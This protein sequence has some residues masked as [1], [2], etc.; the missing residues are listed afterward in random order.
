MNL[1]AKLRQLSKRL[2]APH[3]AHDFIILEEP[4]EE[5]LQAVEA[6]IRACPAEHPARR[7]APVIVVVKSWRNHE[8]APA[9]SEASTSEIQIID[10]S[11][12][13]PDDSLDWAE[14]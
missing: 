12:E 10:Y 4:T 8:L 13:P 1:K 9:D 6:E 3:C 5:A 11:V 7:G 2:P 14:V